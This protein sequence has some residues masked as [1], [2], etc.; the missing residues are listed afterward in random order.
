MVDAEGIIY[1]IAGTGEHGFSGE[2]IS[3]V[4]AELNWPSDIAI[5]SEDN[6]YIADSF[7]HC[8]RKIDNNGI[9]TTFAGI[10]GEQGSEGIGGKPTEIKLDRPY[11]IAFDS[12]DNLYIADT[13][14]H[15]ILIVTKY[16]EN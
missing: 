15:R 2:G 7:N 9:I 4:N 10:P 12:Q 11:G 13:Q 16:Q 1:S 8:I 3:A 5:D 6:I 14:N